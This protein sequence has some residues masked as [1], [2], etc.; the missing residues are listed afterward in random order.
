MK[1]RCFVHSGRGRSL[2]SRHS[3][4]ARTLAAKWKIDR[5]TAVFELR[6]FEHEVEDARRARARALE[7]AIR[8][9]QEH[10]ALD[11]NRKSTSKRKCA[12]S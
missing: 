2:C 10:R 12:R 7:A 1:K 8:T 9:I 3:R 6:A 4:E 5:E 11:A